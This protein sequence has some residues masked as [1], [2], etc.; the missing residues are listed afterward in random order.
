[1]TIHRTIHRTVLSILT[2]LLA[3]QT[4]SSQVEP[5][6]T[7]SLEQCRRLALSNNKLLRRTQHQIEAAGYDRSQAFAAYLPSIDFE[8]AYAY[9]QKEISM[10][11]SDQLL[12]I[13]NFDPQKGSYEFA[14]VTNP[15]TGQPVMVDGKPVPQQVAFLPKDA[16]T[17]N[18]HNVFFGAVTLTQPVFMGGKI[19]AMNKIASLAE[20]LAR[21]RRDSQAQDV[22]YA[23]DAAYWQIVSLHAK[24]ELAVSYVNLLD[25][26]SH[27]VE[28]MLREGVATQRDLLTV[29]VRLNS[30]KVDLLKV[31]NGL[32]LSRMALS[33]LCGI[34]IHTPYLLADENA[35]AIA[36]VAEL[37]AAPVDI[38]EV[39]QR[40][41]DLRQL[42]LAVDILGQKEKVARADM[43]PSLALVGAYSFSNPNLFNGF[44]RRF[45]GAFSVGAV[46]KVP[47]WHWGANYNKV[48]SARAQTAAMR[49]QLE[50]ARELVDLQVQ[51]ATYKTSEAYETL[52][53]TRANLSEADENLRCADLGFRDGVMTVDNVMEAQT[54][55][56]KAH[57]EDIDARIDL[58]LCNV[59]LSKVLGTLSTSE[60]R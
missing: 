20:D 4:L 45:G 6:S 31:K 24:H 9:N 22:V 40:R 1:M 42:R 38:D 17:Y 54:A 11:S 3:V 37:P 15:A 51:Q 29:N 47:I 60:I 48:R 16:L 26:L 13:K 23:V 32:E 18:I 12:P 5:G 19:V 58:Y 21:A 41:D 35:D 25:T 53:A 55:W 52:R 36:Q 34:P 27:N 56:L 46:L 10:F 44:S 2:F 43:L 33:H 39:Y 50:D 49:M 57:S 14:L 8:G 28:A 7:L 30:A 59:Y